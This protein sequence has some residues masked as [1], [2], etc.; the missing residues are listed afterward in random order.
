VRR[1]DTVDFEMEDVHVLQITGAGMDVNDIGAA[2]LSTPTR[3]S[4]V[5]LDRR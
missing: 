2:L 4:A 3:A 5:V 1:L